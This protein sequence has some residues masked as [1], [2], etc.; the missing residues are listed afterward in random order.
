M[1]NRVYPIAP[2]VNKKAKNCKTVNS[3][4]TVLQFCATCSIFKKIK[5]AFYL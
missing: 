4:F 1:N 3:M 5:Q 2:F